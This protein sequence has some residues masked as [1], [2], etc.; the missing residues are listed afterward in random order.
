MAIFLF[1]S[2]SLCFFLSFFSADSITYEKLIAQY[3]GSFV[4]KPEK[5]RW[6]VLLLFG[7]ISYSAFDIL[8]HGTGGTSGRTDA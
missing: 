3:S 4:G 6:P 8:M 7:G 2:L 1:L 5:D